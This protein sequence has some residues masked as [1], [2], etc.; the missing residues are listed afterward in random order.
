M[1]PIVFLWAHPRSMSTA[2]ERIMRERGD[3]ECLHEPFLHHYYLELSDKPLPHFASKQNHPSGYRETRDFILQAAETSPVFAKDMSYYVMA[4]IFEDPEFCR[5][6]QHCFLIRNPLRSIASYFKLD[7]SMSLREV[8]IKTQWQHYS[9]LLDIG[10]VPGPVLEAEAIQA[11]SAGMM[12][13][14][15]RELGLDFRAHA[16]EWKQD[17]VPAD[18]EY[19]KGW[20]RD[21][22]QSRG[23]RQAPADE[24]AQAEL[25]FEKLC[26]QAPHLRDY[27]D[28]HMPFYRHL[29]E[30]SVKPQPYEIKL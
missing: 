1:N 4:E 12:R 9:R 22:S 6:I 8:G 27:L 16:L 23:I 2:I 17:A 26:Q 21:V 14:F 10:I 19:V 15:W 3:F 25:E 24:Q 7:A 28:F 20:H 5:R 30:V 13:R 18:W 11:D 29:Q